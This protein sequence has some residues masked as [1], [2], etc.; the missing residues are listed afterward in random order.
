[1]EFN[2]LLLAAIAGITELYRRLIHRDFEAAGLI[3][4][5]A[6]SGAVLS[7]FAL[8]ANWFDGMLAGFSASGLISIVGSVA[9]KSSPVPTTLTER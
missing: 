5:A 8:A 2:P 6:V 7:H 4:V 9:R 3:A 1:M